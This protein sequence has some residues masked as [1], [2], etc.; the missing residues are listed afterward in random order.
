MTAQYTI[1]AVT[2]ESSLALDADKNFVQQRHSLPCLPDA[3]S[4]SLRP[5]RAR[6]TGPG[7]RSG[8]RFPARPRTS[9]WLP[10]A[11]PLGGAFKAGQHQQQPLLHAVQV[12]G[13]RTPCPLQPRV[14]QCFFAAE[15]KVQGKPDSV[16]RRPGRCPSAPGVP[17]THGQALLLLRRRG[18][19][20][21]PNWPQVR[22]L[23]VRAATGGQHP[24]G[25]RG[26]RPFLSPESLPAQTERVCCHWFSTAALRRGRRRYVKL[27]ASARTPAGSQRRRAW[28]IRRRSS[29]DAPRPPL[30][31][32]MMRQVTEPPMAAIQAAA[33]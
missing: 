31:G 4:D 18:P 20:D 1:P 12:G 15:E 17:D 26:H 10:H 21:R 2:A 23:Q 9:R 30:W 25:G 14:G 11:S 7:V 22:D 16:S 19:S 6:A 29:I 5:V 28:P 33:F 8:R 32:L 3:I 24:S 13:K 27:S